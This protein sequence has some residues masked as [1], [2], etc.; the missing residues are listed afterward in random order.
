MELAQSPFLFL[1]EIMHIWCW[2]SEAEEEKA[3]MVEL[4]VAIDD[5]FFIFFMM[6]VEE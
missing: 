3:I 6:E 2:E 1:E 5:F 4:E